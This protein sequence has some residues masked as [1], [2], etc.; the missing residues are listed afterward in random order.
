MTDPERIAM[1]PDAAQAVMSAL[2]ATAEALRA[3][4]AAGIGQIAA[5]DGQL[6]NGPLGRAI[7]ADYNAAVQG[8]RDGAEQTVERVGQ[9]GDAG[10]RIVRMYMDTDARTG[11]YFGF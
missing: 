3:D 2:V 8:I 5:L 4:W 7:A 11:Q 6:G 1:D 9:L 10:T